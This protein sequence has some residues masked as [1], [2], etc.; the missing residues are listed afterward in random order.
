MEVEEKRQHVLTKFRRYK[1]QSVVTKSD[2]NILILNLKFRWSPKVQIKQKGIYNLKDES[3][4]DAFRENTSH[5]SNLTKL[6]QTENIVSGGAQ[7]IKEVNHQIS[8]SFKK[9]RISTNRKKP[10]TKVTSLL[11]KRE[12]IKQN[13][14]TS[15]NQ[16]IKT[17]LEEQLKKVDKDIVDIE[18]HTNH[19]NLKEQIENIEDDNENLNCIKMRLV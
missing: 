13:F 16:I 12:S 6:V 11:Q 17:D 10:S 9:I 19:M 15:N 8:K 2:H 18:S 1:N 14:A 3:G 4:L 7:W 5:C